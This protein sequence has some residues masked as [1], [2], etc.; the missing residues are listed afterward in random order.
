MWAGRLQ[1]T[2]GLSSHTVKLNLKLFKNP[3]I[4][5]S[6]NTA[7][8]TNVMRAK[9]SEPLT[10][11]ITSRTHPSSLRTWLSRYR[12]MQLRWDWRNMSC[13]CQTGVFTFQRNRSVMTHLTSEGRGSVFTWNGHIGPGLFFPPQRHKHC[14][15]P[16]CSLKEVV[17][18]QLDPSAWKHF[19]VP[20]TKRDKAHFI[21][22]ITEI[23]IHK[24]V[25]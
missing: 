13:C 18:C 14:D 12:K 23:R 16:V 25:L 11:T 7:D 1:I 19:L 10:S 4:T 3:K 6:V 8:Y 24:T 20:M 17:D 9:G 2:D 5:L 22:Q 21:D 15:V